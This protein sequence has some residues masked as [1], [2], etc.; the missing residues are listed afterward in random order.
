MRIDAYRLLLCV[1]ADFGKRLYRHVFYSII[2][3]SYPEFFRGCRGSSMLRTD[4]S[5]LQCMTMETDETRRRIKQK[6]RLSK[7]ND[8][9]KRKEK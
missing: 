6:E 2:I 7:V 5:Q 3:L 9:A 1:P 4:H 8:Q